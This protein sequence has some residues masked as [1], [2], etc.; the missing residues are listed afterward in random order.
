MN[1]KVWNW[2]LS[3]TVAALVIFVIILVTKPRQANTSNKEATKT[4]QQASQ[5]LAKN[6][7]LIKTDPNKV[8]DKPDVPAT[9][10]K[11]LTT[12]SNIEEIQFTGEAG[13]KLWQ[14][15]SGLIPIFYFNEEL[16]KKAGYPDVKPLTYKGGKVFDKKGEYYYFSDG[17]K[18]VTPSANIDSIMITGNAYL[19]EKQEGNQTYEAWLGWELTS[20]LRGVSENSTAKLWLNPKTG[21]IDFAMKMKGYKFVNQQ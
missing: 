5:D 12:T 4:E 20:Q 11:S 14:G 18:A 8:I 3:I 9:E 17:W 16:L 19:G 13:F 1:A 6:E 10:A 15:P 7:N 21:G 2:I